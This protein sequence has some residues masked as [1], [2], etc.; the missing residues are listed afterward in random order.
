MATRRRR[1]G[2]LYYLLLTLVLFMVLYSFTA[3]GFVGQL[4]LDIIMLAILVAVVVLVSQTRRSLIISLLLGV[5]WLIMV[6][7][8]LFV[9]VDRT[10][11]CGT[12]AFGILFLIYVTAVVFRN[13]VRSKRVTADTI[14]GAISVYLLLGILWGV[15]Y[16]LLES[17]SPGS[18]AGPMGIDP[19]T[20][21]EV[22][23]YVYFSFTTLTTLGYGDITPLSAPAR[24]I[25]ILEAVA[26]PLYITILISQLVAKYVSRKVEHEIEDDQV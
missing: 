25:A 16:R 20:G 21:I 7:L 22:P 24:A 14:Y 19:E 13:V 2:K 18:F 6:F 1:R 4:V 15:A 12:T 5:P 23:S 9:V 11:Y 8:D 17:I 26:G 3:R 10:L